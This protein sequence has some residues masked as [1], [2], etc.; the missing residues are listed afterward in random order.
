ML[1][2]FHKLKSIYI[3]IFIYF[4]IT[5]LSGG[6]SDAYTFIIMLFY[7][8][9]TYYKNKFN[10]LV[11][12]ILIFFLIL[13]SQI[14]ESF[15]QNI[16]SFTFIN[17]FNNFLWQQGSSLNLIQYSIEYKNR[18]IDGSFNLFASYI[19]PF[20]SHIINNNYT[21]LTSK[22][23]ANKLSFLVNPDMAIR[24]YGLGLSFIAEIFLSLNYLGLV[25]FSFLLS[26]LLII[27][28]YF[29]D[30]YRLVLIINLF[31]LPLIFFLPRSEIFFI[32]YKLTIFLI[33][34]ISIYILYKIISKNINY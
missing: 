2:S 33:Y 22:R 19:E 1:A 27:F 30:K 12:F 10:P 6:R 4:L 23:L 20:T 15:R 32:F 29:S 31:I 21:L 26:K 11:I 16:F 13:L 8:Y 34:S 7:F 18:L 3:F 5:I 17:V 9:N 24:G 28:N 14:I 25:L